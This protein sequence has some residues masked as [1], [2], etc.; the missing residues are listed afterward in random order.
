MVDE[1]IKETAKGEAMVTDYAKWMGIAIIAV[2]VLGLLM[3]EGLLAGVINIDVLE[4]IVHLLTG[5]L[6]AYVGFAGRNIRTVRTVV[7]SIGVAYLLVG[8]LGLITPTLFGLL[9][10]GYT[11]LDNGLHL[12]LGVA[13]IAVAWF[14]A[15]R[16]L[17]V[18]TPSAMR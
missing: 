18:V 15:G 8:V 6:M 12:L 16:P 10:H 1:R 4:D 5:G 11:A 14:L 13:G 7:G 3:G 2:G 9:P 17:R